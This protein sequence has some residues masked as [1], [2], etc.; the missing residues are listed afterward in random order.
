M[1]SREP[2]IKSRDSDFAFRLSRKTFTKETKEL[3]AKTIILNLPNF[4]KPCLVSGIDSVGSKAALANLFGRYR[5]VGYDAVA[6]CVN[7]VIRC[8]A[9][10][11]AFLPYI[12]RGKLDQKALME[13]MNGIVSACRDSSCAII[14]GETASMLGFYKEKG[15]H[16][17][18]GCAIGVLERRDVITGEKIRNSDVILGL[19]S[20]GLHSNGF[21]QIL[22]IFKKSE[23]TRHRRLLLT[24]TRIYVKTVQK[25]LEKKIKVSSIVH[26]T[27]GGM[28]KKIGT[29]LPPGLKANVITTSF[30]RPKIFEIIA[31]TGKISEGE[32]YNNFNMGI[33]MAIVLQKNEAKKAKD[34]LKSWGEKCF[35]IGYIT[36]RTGDKVIFH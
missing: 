10:P 27:G 24:P 8:G 31:G 3:F 19:S 2:Q 4:K 11:V 25:L 30:P 21:S 22:K 28:P 17:I 12:G 9:R 34:V 6:M 5:E 1:K 7:D 26:I 15:Q 29:I 33:G 14:G 20:S 35:G 16:E 36:R 13:I 32:M 23:L 18:A